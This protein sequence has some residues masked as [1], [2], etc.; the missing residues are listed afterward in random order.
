M[1]LTGLPV[2]YQHL[3]SSSTS[4]LTNFSRKHH[5]C[6]SATWKLVIGEGETM[7]LAKAFLPLPLSLKAPK[8][9]PLISLCPLSTLTT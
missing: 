1:F 3:T 5:Q 4:T 8:K 2:K 6:D 9:D 7:L